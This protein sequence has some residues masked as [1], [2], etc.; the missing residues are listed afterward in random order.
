M[1]LALKDKVAL[2]GGASQGLGHA[3]A[4][5][6]AAEGVKVSICARNGPALHQAARAIPA[7]AEN[8]LAVPTDLTKT[9]S[10]PPVATG[11]QSISWS[12]ML[13]VPR[14]ELLKT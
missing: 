12:I 7:P 1:N 3:I 10:P 14:P 5:A 13:A 4:M 6:L 2:I 8:I 11:E 9:G